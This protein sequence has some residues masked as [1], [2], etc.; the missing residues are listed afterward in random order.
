MRNIGKKQDCKRNLEKNKGDVKMNKLKNEKGITLINLIILFLL[1]LILAAVLYLVYANLV[2]RGI[3]KSNN[4]LANDTNIPQT[5]NNSQGQQNNLNEENE[6]NNNSYIDDSNNTEETDIIITGSKDDDETEEIDNNVDLDEPSNSNSGITSENTYKTGD[7][8][9]IERNK[10][11]ITIDSIE[12]YTNEN[13]YEMKKAKVTFTN[14]NEQALENLSPLYYMIKPV[15]I[16]TEG[17]IL[18]ENEYFLKSGSESYEDNLLEKPIEAGETITG[19]IYWQSS[20][21]EYIK[22]SSI[23]GIIDSE[24]NE[25]S[26]GD[27]F[28]VDISEEN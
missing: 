28:Y 14:N 5:M 20:K 9:N 22:I 1:I 16:M 21:A 13:G 10:M 8:I 15:S 25:Y 26:Y 11:E 23:T 18:E 12:S 27:S 4:N 6:L 24:N 3:I 17:D 2:S 7:T 19:Y